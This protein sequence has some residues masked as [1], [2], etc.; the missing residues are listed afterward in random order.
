MLLPMHGAHGAGAPLHTLR[1]RARGWGSCGEMENDAAEKKLIA[2]HGVAFRLGGI[3]HGPD[4]ADPERQ[5]AH[6]LTVTFD[7][8]EIG[9]RK[10]QFGLALVVRTGLNAD[11]PTPM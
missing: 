1:K 2:R 6:H 11:D 7:E 8:A 10:F 3:A 9:I 5:P 4:I